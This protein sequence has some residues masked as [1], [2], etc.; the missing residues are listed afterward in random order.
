MSIMYE[1][2]TIYI[3]NNDYNSN[4]YNSSNRNRLELTC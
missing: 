1:L 4:I 3:D 2:F